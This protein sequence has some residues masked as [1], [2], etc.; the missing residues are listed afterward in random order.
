MGESQRR[1]WIYVPQRPDLLDAAYAW[2]RRK[3]EQGK[4]YEVIEDTSPVGGDELKRVGSDDVLY[5]LRTSVL[6]MEGPEQLAAQLLAHGLHHGHRAVKIFASCSGDTDRP[7]ASEKASYAERL[8]QAMRKQ[9]PRVVVYGF[10]GKVSPEGVAGHKTAGLKPGEKLDAI[11]ATE[12][13]TRGLRA[14]DNRVR[15]PSES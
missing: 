9:F 6:E 10:L 7:G 8:Y 15:F 13:K 11:S 1:H 4:W 14:K 3:T 5:I 12:W 2:K